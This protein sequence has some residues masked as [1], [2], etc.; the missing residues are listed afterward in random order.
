MFSVA[1]CAWMFRYFG[2]ENVRIMD[3]GFQKWL[4]EGL[5]VFSG[6]YTPGE[7]LPADGDYS[8][9][10]G[11][12]TQAITD[13]RR[14]H[15]IADELH[16]GSKI[17]QITDARAPARFNGEVPEPRNMRAGNITGSLNTPYSELIDPFTGCL[18]SNEDLKKVFDARG[19]DLSKKT[20]HSCGSGVTACIVELAWTISGGP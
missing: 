5:P 8:Y 14:I 19:V 13:I 20:V 3:G 9:L 12:S 15:Q 10:A 4:K 2:A 7:G 17:W 6:P 1:R 11:D 16:N 18:K